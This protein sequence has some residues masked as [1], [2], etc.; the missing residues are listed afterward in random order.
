MRGNRVKG[1]CYDS[2]IK[3][4]KQVLWEVGASIRYPR[5]MEIHK[6]G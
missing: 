3:K 2:D 6:K 5:S 1:A 4:T